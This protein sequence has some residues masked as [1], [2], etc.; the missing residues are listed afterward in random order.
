[1]IKSKG[2]FVLLTDP[3]YGVKFKGKLNKNIR[4]LDGYAVEIGDDERYIVEK[5][6]PIVELA[7]ALSKRGAIFSGIRNLFS[8]PRPSDIGG[9]FVP[10][11]SGIGRWGFTS[12]SPILY[13]GVDPYL[14]KGLGSRPNSW[15]T[16]AIAE[17]CDHPCPKPFEWIL[18]L[19]R[20]ISLDDT[21]IILDPFLGSGTTCVAAK[22]LGRLSIGVE[23]GEKYCEI[24]AKRVYD[25]FKGS[26]P[27][28]VLKGEQIKKKG[29]FY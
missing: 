23:I 5:V 3:P 7:L 1:M 26:N 16:Q 12:I 9:F 4:H 2:E 19:L 14:A 24:A 15:V 6:I 11:G 28:A 13:Y 20:R 25:V 10:F 21:D 29:L 8:Y 18:R 17:K 27:K 22:S